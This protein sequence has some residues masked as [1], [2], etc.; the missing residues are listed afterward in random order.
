MQVLVKNGVAMTAALVAVLL[1]ADVGSPV[2]GT[3]TDPYAIYERCV[4]M[5]NSDSSPPYT[6]YTLQIDAQHIDISRG[7][8][9]T[10]APTTMLHFGAF[11]QQ[12]TYRVWYRARDQKSVTQD[13]TSHAA[14]LAPPVPWALD[15]ATPLTSTGSPSGETTSADGVAVDQATQLLSQVKVD[16][17]NDYRITLAG[18]EQYAGHPAYRLALE[19]IGGDPND[20]PL[21]MLLV[22]AVSFR[23]LQIVIEVGQRTLFYG[24]GVTMSASFSEVGGY[25]LST[26]GSIIGNGRFAFIQV[27]GTY[28]YSA[29]HFVFPPQLPES[30]FTIQP[31]P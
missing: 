24:G 29:S 17:K 5:M 15:L 31:N 1:L 16:A 18:E 3:L 12:K 2:T 28:T 10:G 9:K 30:M 4:A 6:I 7:Y 26:R 19:N 8:T 13:V 14:A 23:P 22:D 21:R 25:W 11:D 27:H 20:H